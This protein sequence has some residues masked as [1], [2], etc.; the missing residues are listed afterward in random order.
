MP[1]PLLIPAITAGIGAIGSA[2]SNKKS[3]RT[4]TSTMTPTLAPEYKTLSDLLRSRAEDRLR[5][6]VDLSG[7]TA[8]GVENINNAF[9]GIQQSIA[10]NL[11]ARGLASSP[12]A[13]AVGANV[14]IARGGN[15][16][17]FLNTIPQLQRQYQL[18]DMQ[19][20]LPILNLG[21]GTTTVGIEP[22]SATG[23]ALSTIGGLLGYLHAQGVIGGNSTP[24]RSTVQLPY[25][26]LG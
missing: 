8:G 17:Q 1:F 3:A 23:S 4:G 6:S 24:R 26:G 18:E 22:G 10:N 9:G 25:P 2:L 7:Y 19:A 21:R 15:I 14:D 5:S 20:A 16:A 12:V 11:T 13:G